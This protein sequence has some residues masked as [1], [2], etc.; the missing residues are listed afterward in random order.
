[1]VYPCNKEGT[2]VTCEI[3]DGDDIYIRAYPKEGY[4]FSKW[5]G[6]ACQD[7]GGASA[8]LSQGEQG[9]FENLFYNTTHQTCTAIFTPVKC[10]DGYFSLKPNTAYFKY[11]SDTN[12]CYKVTGCKAPYETKAAETCSTFLEKYQPQ[13]VSCYKNDKYYID[14]IIYDTKL[15]KNESAGTVTPSKVCFSSGDE[16]LNKTIATAK[17]NNGYIFEHWDPAEQIDSVHHSNDDP[18]LQL[19]YQGGDELLEDFR[20]D[21]RYRSGS[22]YAIFRPVGYYDFY[23]TE[24]KN[25]PGGDGNDAMITLTCKSNIATTSSVT[26][27]AKFHWKVRNIYRNDDWWEDSMSGGRD[28][29]YDTEEDR[30]VTKT[31]PSGTKEFTIIGEYKYYPSFYPSAT[32]QA[33][34]VSSIETND[35]KVTVH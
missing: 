17:P 6:E 3:V 21:D 18:K 22:I 5:E 4:K 31:I 33:G 19:Y 29:V 34:S 35:S 28:E 14:F 12:G 24:N 1:M 15:N 7:N 2:S 13:Q 20:I 16:L 32:A 10:D 8:W 11:T 26:I 23:C 9:A 25:I 30:A 27:T